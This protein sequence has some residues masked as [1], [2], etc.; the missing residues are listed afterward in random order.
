MLYTKAVDNEAF[1]VL[2][3]LMHDRR[4]SNH[5]LVGGTAL[6]LYKGNRE[7]YDLDLFTNKPFNED[8]LEKYLVDKYD[9]KTEYKFS[10]SLMGYIDDIKIDFI[11]HKYKYLEDP[12]T[13]KGI[14]M[15]SMKDITAMKLNAITGSGHRVKDFVDIAYLSTEFSLSEMISFY[16][17]K[18]ETLSSI[19][20]VKALTYFSD[21]NHSVKIEL[22]NANYSWDKIE[23]R[24]INMVENINE[25]FKFPPIDQ[26]RQG[27]DLSM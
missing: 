23:K 18:Y 21:I 17:K 27:I 1:K 3:T 22:I 10:N 16:E 2:V 20:I 24:I 12:L 6:A 19:I 4:L 15:C 14:R 9:F 13:I 5:Y 11:T 8:S 26:S 25:I 7:S